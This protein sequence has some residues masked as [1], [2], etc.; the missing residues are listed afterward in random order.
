M[1]PIESEPVN[2]ASVDVEDWFHIL[3]LDDT[4]GMDAWDN[5]ESRVE[6]NLHVLLD[7][8]DRHGVRVT[9]F[10]LGWVAERFPDLVREADSRGH[11]IASHGYGHQLIF[12]QTAADLGR[13]VRRA[14][15]ILEEIVMKPV[16]GYRAPGFSITRETPWAFEELVQAG[17]TYDSSVFPASRG[18][19]GLAGARTDPH[20]V[21]TASGPLL[22]L[23]ISVTPFMGRRMCFFGGGYLRLFP[24]RLIARKARAVNDDGRPVIYY[25]HPREI[26]PHHPRLPMGAVRR[27]KSYVNLSTTAGKL[28][29]IMR[30]QRLTTFKAWIAAEG[31]RLDVVRHDQPSGP[32][33][34]YPDRSRASRR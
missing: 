29:A 28:E 18:H 15:A 22:E 6:R 13:D 32:V 24:W 25:V 1:R 16:L 27:F 31:P 9:C 21:A 14:K 23:P 10:F 34:V 5:M 3:D 11:E 33:H 4:P 12:D 20:V 26:D 19:G 2:I 7:A 30:S 8:F 17:H